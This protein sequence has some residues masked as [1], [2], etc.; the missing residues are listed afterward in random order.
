MSCCSSSRDR[1]ILNSRLNEYLNRK[2]RGKLRLP[3]KFL[4][5]QTAMSKMSFAQIRQFAYLVTPERAVD[6]TIP[7]SVVDTIRLAL[8]GYIWTVP[9]KTWDIA[10]R[11]GTHRLGKEEWP[12]ISRSLW[13]STPSFVE[14]IEQSRRG[15]TPSGLWKPTAIKDSMQAFHVQDFPTVATRIVRQNIFGI[16]ETVSVPDKFLNWFR[17]RGNILFL[18]VRHIL[19]IG[20]VRFLLG[21]WIR[22]PFNLWLKVNCR[23]RHYLKL[24][25]PPKWVVNLPTDWTFQFIGEVG[26]AT[27]EPFNTEID[28][29]DSLLFAELM[30]S[31]RRNQAH[32]K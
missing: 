8:P 32:P 31:V 9:G 1:K 18:T 15:K 28:D 14:M 7:K 6:H 4:D 27:L 30:S 5:L 16:R 12:R 21:Q 29:E 3:R 25:K 20:L 17:R 11:V 2:R 24:L 22:N 19:P 23:F 13:P 26:V 10:N